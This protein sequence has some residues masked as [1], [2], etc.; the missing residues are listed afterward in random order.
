M[1]KC[2][3]N[4]QKHVGLSLEWG[5]KTSLICNPLIPTLFLGFAVIK[6]VFPAVV[7]VIHRIAA[8][9]LPVN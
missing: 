6:L 4:E 3:F 8:H 9:V 1:F 5:S 2:S 7:A